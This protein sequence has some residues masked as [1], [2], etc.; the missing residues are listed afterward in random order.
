[1]IGR[2]LAADT[3]VPGAGNPGSLNRY[4]YVL[5][6]PLRFN[7]PS[8][9]CIPEEDC[10][11]SG[12]LRGDP[13]RYG[14]D[15]IQTSY[16][17]IIDMRHYLLARV[18]TKIILDDIQWNRQFTAVS[19][20]S[21]PKNLK[22]GQTYSYRLNGNIPADEH[23]GVAVGILVDSSGH[24]EGFQGIDPRKQSSY[25]F[26]DIPS[27]YLGAVSE[28]TNMSWK[29][30]LNELGGAWRP[31]HWEPK[32][33]PENMSY[34]PQSPREGGQWVCSSWPDTLNVTPVSADSG[35][36][37]YHA[38]TT[39]VKPIEYTIPLWTSSQ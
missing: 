3:I 12:Y 19:R 13:S 14:I 20:D 24:F 39:Y 31:V 15:Y 16:G 5:N 23:I 38:S 18:N 30:V 32:N 28:A 36:W 6:N 4:S 8:G 26:E 27:D 37:S 1:M 34:A 33:A 11:E 2:F 7:D 9:H 17:Y 22:V 10:P 25:S 21:G 29:E 35:W